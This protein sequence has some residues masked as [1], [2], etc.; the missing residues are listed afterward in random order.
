MHVSYQNANPRRGN[1]STILRFTDGDAKAV[2]LVDS[3]DGVDL[4]SLLAADEYLNGVLLTHAHIDHYRTLGK[5]VRHN[6]P[7]YV[8]PAT[9]TIL[10]HSLSEARKDNDLGDVDAVLD[11]IEPIGEWTPVL[12]GLEIRPV[13]A[14]HTPGAAGFLVRFRETFGPKGDDVASIISDERYILVT[15]DFTTRPC[16]GFPPLPTSFPV[17]V[18]AV[19]L[20]ASTNETT[21]EQ[22]NEALQTILER[23]YGGSRVVVAA[24]ALTGVQYALLLAAIAAE[25][26]RSLSI[27][28]VGQ[29]A[30]VLDALDI[31]RPEI[32]SC[33][34]FD[35]PS[36]VLEAETVTIAGPDSP[37]TGSAKRLLLAIHDRPADAFVQL[38]TDDSEPIS[39]ANCS[40]YAFRSDNHPSRDELDEV[41][42]AIAPKHLVVKHASGY[43]LDTFQRRY[44]RC[45]TWAPDDGVSRVLY[46]DGEWSKPGWISESAAR[47][48]RHRQWKTNGDRPL[49][50][51]DDSMSLLRQPVDPDAEGVD[52]DAFRSQFS[53]SVADPYDDQVALTDRDDAPPA[54][55][56]ATVPET[57][58]FEARVFGD[59]DGKTLLEVLE[60]TDFSPGEIVEV[61]LSRPAED[62]D[63]S[64]NRDGLEQSE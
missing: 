4:D 17:D 64:E 58:R 35:R 28:V 27:T 37:T 23:A 50:T 40:T 24:S 9:G 21:I 49:A 12:E 2:L 63:S 31:E 54:S 5:N 46:E 29:T 53:G 48:I 41:V 59:G 44:D 25:L 47:R 56:T 60:S 32:E 33:A 34:V 30:R 26:D 55:E 11:S 45:F 13:P 15:G 51:D 61:S 8:S 10:E 16:A 42:R 43:R 36:D 19:F 39:N 22:R 20:N 6:A 57:D 38:A 62:G 3:G 18:D 14:G 1:E 7:V 52:V